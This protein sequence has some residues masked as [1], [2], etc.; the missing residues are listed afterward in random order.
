MEKRGKKRDRNAEK[1]IWKRGKRKEKNRHIT[2]SKMY[3][4]K[5]KRLILMIY[6]FVEKHLTFNTAW[7]ECL[8]MVRETGVQ[9][10][11]ESY[12]R[13][14][15]WHLIPSCLTLSNI[16]YV[17]RVKWSNPGKGVAPSPTPR[18]CS[19]WKENLLVALDYNRQQTVYSSLKNRTSVN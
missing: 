11:V 13:L 7:V 1:I 3:F 9:S 5:T 10:Q 18:C 2:V 17:S 19:Y 4:L 16:R 14:L 8:Q 12:Q 15:K 6:V